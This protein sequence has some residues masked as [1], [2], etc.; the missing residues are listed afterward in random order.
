M[1]PDAVAQA[2]KVAREAQKFW[3][4]PSRTHK[5]RAMRASPAA[6]IACSKASD[7]CGDS[8]PPISRNDSA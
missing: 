1:R 8:A 4:Y 5:P 6:K 3:L 2:A 7:V